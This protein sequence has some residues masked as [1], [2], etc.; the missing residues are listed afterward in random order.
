MTQDEK[1]AQIVAEARS[2][3]G[4]P[5][6][7]RGR[8]KGAGCD[9]GSLLMQIAVNCGLMTNEELEVY[10][11][12]CWAHWRDERYLAHVM[13]HT[14]KV[15]ESI[16]YRSTKILPGSLILTRAAGSKHLNHGAI[17]TAW[18]LIIHA[19]S[20]C[21]EEVDVTTHHLWAYRPIEVFEFNGV[22]G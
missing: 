12:D 20:P 21:V 2:W 16:A 19:V 14:R 8:V 1:R 7:V 13:K 11:V 4:T 18:P 22:T 3:V 5:Y 10:S 15:L 6:I 9:C 17:V